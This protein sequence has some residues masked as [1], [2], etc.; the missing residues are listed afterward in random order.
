MGHSI[1]AEDNQFAVIRDSGS[2]RSSCGRSDDNVSWFN[3]DPSESECLRITSN[4]GDEDSKHFDVGET[5]DISWNG[6][7]LEDA[8]VVRSD[9]LGEDAG[10]VVFEGVD[11]S[12]ASVTIVWTPD[13][14]LD[15]WYDSATSKGYKTGVHNTDQNAS[16]DYSVMCFGGDVPILTPDGARAA[17]TLGVGDRVLTLDNG[18]AKIAWIG[19]TTVSGIGAAAPVEFAPNTIGNSETMVLSQQ[20]RVL[21]ASNEGALLFGSYE[22]LLPAKAF[23]GLDGV[24]LRP[25]MMQEYVHI[26]TENHEVI[27]AA[28]APCET[29]FLG[30]MA[31]QYGQG[32]H[33]NREFFPDFHA[34]KMA[35]AGPARPMLTVREAQ[36]VLGNGHRISAPERG[37][38][39][40]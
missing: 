33:E 40:A 6:G 13:F 9:G 24:R 1:D 26:L 10:V 27:F 12:G 30:D 16:V 21:C 11:E 37:L 38:L 7:T 28:G 17:A 3:E 22:N 23:V 31:A 15:S 4:D 5:Y 25:A 39:T 8:V 35:H 14:D 20:H 32:S 36:M 2:D 34:G 18:F 29:L 19:R